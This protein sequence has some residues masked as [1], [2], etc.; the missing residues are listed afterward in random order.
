[1]TKKQKILISLVVIGVAIGTGSNIV[2]AAYHAR[3]SNNCGVEEGQY[4]TSPACQPGY[5]ECGDGDEYTLNAWQASC[6]SYPGNVYYTEYNHYGFCS[7]WL[8]DDYNLRKFIYVAYYYPWLGGGDHSC[9]GTCSNNCYASKSPTEQAWYWHRTIEKGAGSTCS[10]DDF[11]R[12][13][14]AADQLNDFGWYELGDCDADAMWLYDD[15]CADE[16]W[17]GDYNCETSLSHRIYYDGIKWEEW[18]W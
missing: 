6:G 16:M 4:W 5:K 11:Y 3:C 9:S 8:G 7:S 10:V 1:M 12:E 2:Q 17:L 14:P 13:S 15:D 18:D